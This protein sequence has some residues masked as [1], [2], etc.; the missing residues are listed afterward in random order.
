MARGVQGKS[1]APGVRAARALLPLLSGWTR[2]RRRTPKLKHEVRAHAY[3]AEPRERLSFIPAHAQAP[4]RK[5]VVYIHGGGWIAG[6]KEAYTPYLG[7]L[8]DAGYPVFNL[9]YPLA[10]ENPHPG[11]LRSLLAALD[12]IADANPNADSIHLMGDSAGGNLAM[13]L[14][15]LL[16]NPGLLEAVDPSRTRPLGLRCSSVIS[17][18]GVLDRLS[19]IEDGFP[20]AEM[21]LENYGG[22]A[23]LEP[24]VE[25]GLALTPMDLQFDSAPPS[26]LAVGTDDP[27]RRSSQIFADRLIAGPNKLVHREYPGEGH[28]FFSLGSTRSDGLLREDVLAFLLSIEPEGIERASVDAATR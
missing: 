12:W 7:F 27:L 26:F 16:E 8:A 4:E 23:A 19:W 25:P 6:K 3:G 11:I 28:G 10:P 1:A 24:E 18:Y 21:M 5:P 14:G 9:G 20:G 22:K 13:M 15:L 2:L 17:L